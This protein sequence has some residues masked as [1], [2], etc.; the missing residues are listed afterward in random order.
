MA[1]DMGSDEEYLGMLEKLSNYV[2]T[3]VAHATL[4]N[5]KLPKH[6]LKLEGMSSSG[7]RLLL[8]NLCM[9]LEGKYLEIGS[10]KGSTF[11]SALYNNPK[12]FGTSID[13]HSEFKS[14]S[15]FKTS[16]E[17]L[18]SNCKKYLLNDE[19][20][21]LITKD[22]FAD[23][24]KLG[25]SEY[26]IYFYDGQ[27][28]FDNR[29]KALTKFYK[30]LTPMFIFICDDY[31]IDRVESGTQAALDDLN[32]KVITEHKMFGHQ[33]TGDSKTSGFWNGFYVALCV[34]KD[35]FPKHF[36]K[37]IPTHSFGGAE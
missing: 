27:H 25:K 28:S 36:K 15:P 6:I 24:L 29:Y 4:G 32:I 30:Y 26:T 10:W 23:D 3:C 35:A 13:H 11:I 19:N 22:C 12:M 20:Y 31:S 16:A 34:K 8:N 9:G 2:N 17:A 7:N 33:E 1:K 14:D 18:E 5:G 21:E 37:A